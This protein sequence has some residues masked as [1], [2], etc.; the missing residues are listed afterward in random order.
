[1]ATNTI[2]WDKLNQVLEDYGNELIAYYRNKLD[3]G[4]I[5]ASYDLYNSLRIIMDTK[6]KGRIEVNLSLIEY[7]KYIEKGRK[8]GKMP[9]ISAIEK[10]VEIKPVLPRPMDNGKLPTTK[11][12]AYLIARK[13]GLEGIAPKPILAESIEKI[14]DVFLPLIEQAVAEDIQREVDLILKEVTL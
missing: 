8:A 10:W 7:W 12:L 5:N 3:D 2:K 14:N 6:T 1:M 11:Q 4:G 9:P 13:I